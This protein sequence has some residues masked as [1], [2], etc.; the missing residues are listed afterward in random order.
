M[1]TN[2]D[3]RPRLEQRLDDKMVT[4]KGSNL[5]CRVAPVVLDV[6]GRLRPDQCAGDMI[7]TI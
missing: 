4:I 3:V 6:N 1:I 2:V 7:V 5:E